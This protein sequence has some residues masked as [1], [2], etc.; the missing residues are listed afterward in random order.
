LLGIPTF[1]SKGVSNKRRQGANTTT[2]SQT[3]RK[4][5]VARIIQNVEAQAE[6]VGPYHFDGTVDGTRQNDNVASFGYHSAHA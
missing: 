6:V 2:A 4:K 5:G 3:K 1:R